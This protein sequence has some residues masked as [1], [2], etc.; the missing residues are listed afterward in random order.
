MNGHVCEN[1]EVFPLDKFHQFGK[2][3]GRKLL[4][5]GESPS[6]KGWVISGKACYRSDG[7]ILPTGK[8]LNEL[9]DP[10]GISVE[11]SGFT[12][13]SKC[14]VSKR[15]E[16]EKCSKKC[17]PLFLSQIKGKNYKLIIL[18]G[19]QTTKI[20]SKLINK[21]LIIGE[22]AD[23]DLNNKQYKVLP[24]FHPSPLNT[25]GHPKNMA[26]FKENQQKIREILG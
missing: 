16:L 19:V 7:K 3:R 1:I 22:I 17:W 25:K 11:T 18:L 6:P 15:S 8:R 21:E 5:V 2:G 9:L 26:L 4:I 14:I 10:F 12:E 24:I 13:L 23:V 20:F